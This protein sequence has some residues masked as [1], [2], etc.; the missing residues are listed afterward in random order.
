MK[1]VKRMDKLVHNAWNTVRANM[2]RIW[3]NIDI[4]PQ[5]SR[6]IF[7]V[8]ANN[9]EINIDVNPIVFLVPERRM[10]KNRLYICVKGRIC[11]ESPIPNKSQ[12][13]TKTFSTSVGYFRGH[14]DNLEHVYGVHY[15][16]VT[17]HFGHPVFHAQMRPQMDFEENIRAQYHDDRSVYSKVDSILRNVRTPSAEM[18]IFSVF[19]QIIADHLI[20]KD[21]DDKEKK[22]F[23][24]TLPSCEFFTGIAQSLTNFDQASSQSRYRSMCW[25]PDC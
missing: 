19:V 23:S 10:S 22:L 21:S 1:D 5:D 7:N 2:F 25:Y 12:P 4:R 20:H 14:T 9:N 8:A 3:S 24:T 13:N 6:S 16:C 15:D 11:F 17:N 18:D